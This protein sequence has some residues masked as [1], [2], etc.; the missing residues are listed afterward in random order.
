MITLKSSREI[1]LMKEA[2]KVVGKVF[3]TIEP[4][5]KPGISSYELNEIIEKVIFEND[6]RLLARS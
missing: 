5:I 1:S 6:T 3:T 4:Y 2:G